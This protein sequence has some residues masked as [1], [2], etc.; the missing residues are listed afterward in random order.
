MEE[1]PNSNALYC[2]MFQRWV[3][4]ASI[5]YILL[6]NLFFLSGWVEPWISVPLCALLIICSWK[7]WKQSKP[8]CP[9]TCPDLKYL[10]CALLIAALYVYRMGFNGDVPQPGDFIV[11]TP[12]YTT[13]IHSDW[14]IYSE[15]GEY[16]V[17]YH[18]YVLPPAWI[19]SILSFIPS[20]LILSTWVYL[21]IALAITCMFFKCGK[22]TAIVFALIL[23]VG[24]LQS[25]FRFDNVFLA[26]HFPFEPMVSFY[27]AHLPVGVIFPGFFNQCAD[28][29]NHGINIFLFFSLAYGKLL[30]GYRLAL[31]SALLVV[32]SPLG[33]VAVLI[34]L[35]YLMIA[36]RLRNELYTLFKQPM[37]YVD[38]LLIAVLGLYFSSGSGAVIE[39]IWKHIDTHEAL[40]IYLVTIFCILIPLFVF[41]WRYRHTT[42]FRASLTIALVTPI[43]WVGQTNNEL[44]F[45]SSILTAFFI[46]VF[47]YKTFCYAG[48]LKRIAIVIVFLFCSYNFVYETYRAARDFSTSDE[49]RAANMHNEWHGSLNHPNHYMYKQFWAEEVPFLYK[50]KN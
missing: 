7:L 42:G 15:R 38:I 11:R 2:S 49:G 14:P 25:L 44:L 24:P 10:L 3:T 39:P 43:V 4:C 34:Y 29:Y 21:G 16:F 41:G 45:K 13:L 46:P 35:L 33:A 22:S 48:I 40:P 27:C 32:I 8:I 19:A 18:A 5:A 6:P 36:P 1:S 31:L 26:R 50:G 20:W 12:I 47:A 30:T 9:R 17:Y 37:L 23:F 28:T